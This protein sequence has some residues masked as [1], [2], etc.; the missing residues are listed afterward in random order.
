MPM[1]RLVRPTYYVDPMMEARSTETRMM[2]SR[3]YTC[4]CFSKSAQENTLTTQA[5]MPSVVHCS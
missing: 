4:A 5:R 1:L 2:M 3:G